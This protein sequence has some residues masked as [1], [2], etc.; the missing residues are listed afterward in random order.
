MDHSILLILI[1]VVQM[2]H[3]S[4]GGGSQGILGDSGHTGLEGPPQALGLVGRKGS[5]AVG[6]G[7]AVGHEKGV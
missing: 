2:V 4:I 7:H 1:L 3:N 6:V 5:F